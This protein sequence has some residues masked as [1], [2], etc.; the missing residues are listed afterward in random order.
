MDYLMSLVG[1]DQ[2]TITEAIKELAENVEK[3]KHQ[4]KEMDELN[5]ELENCK[6]EI[7]YLRN[8]V[9]QKR[10]VIEDMEN[11]LEKIEEKFEKAK[12][13]LELKD[14]ERNVLE[15]LIGEQ[16]EEINILR[17][18]NQSM[19]CQISENVMM[20]RKISVQNAVIKELKDKGK[21]R[22]EFKNQ[23]EDLSKLVDEVKQLKDLNEEKEIQLENIS[24]ENELLIVKLDRLEAIQSENVFLKDKLDKNDEIEKKG[25][26]ESHFGKVFKCK[27][28][29]KTFGRR[30]DLK[31]HKRNVHGEQNSQLLTM[32]YKIE[33]KLLEQKLDLTTKISKMKENESNKRQTCKCIG[34]CAINHIK[35]SWNKSFSKEF[36][37]KFE[38]LKSEKHACNICEVKFEN[39]NQLDNHMQTHKNTNVIDP[40]EAEVSAPSVHKCGHCKE[41]FSNVE[42]FIFHIERNHKEAA[43]MFLA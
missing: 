21:E 31:T 30:G 34:W 23:E 22:N 14:G 11:E 26:L 12:N 4:E 38:N 6:E 19:V 17:D 41:T 28:C 16:V 39:L 33:T 35:H 40:S 1:Q 2:D 5:N 25:E 15:K 18:N 20:E 13:E 24:K 27:E 7:H 29:D 8:K 43:V 3:V 10:D 42:E 37:Y 32:L 36:H 9:D